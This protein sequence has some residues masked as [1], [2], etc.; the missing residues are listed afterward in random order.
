MYCAWLNSWRERNNLN[1]LTRLIWAVQFEKLKC[2]SHRSTY[3]RINHA[4]VRFVE[5]HVD[6]HHVLWTLHVHLVYVRR[7]DDV[8]LQVRLQRLRVGLERRRICGKETRRLVREATRRLLLRLSRL[9]LRPRLNRTPIIRRFTNAFQYN[10][11][12]MLIITIITILCGGLQQY[13]YL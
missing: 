9:L 3:L 6:D 4:V 5:L 10:T 2:S 12:Q 13:S 7:M 8:I 1:T 11:Q